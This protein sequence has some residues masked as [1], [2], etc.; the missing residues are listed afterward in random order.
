MLEQPT[1]PNHKQLKI[2]CRVEAGCLGPQGE[3]LINDYCDYAEQQFNQEKA[4]FVS[5]HVCPRTDRSLPELQYY[6]GNR[7][8][9][10]T[11]A[12]R[13]LN[14]F[15]HDIDTFEM[16]AHERIVCLIEQYMGR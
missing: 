7:R 15:E 9:S 11:Q 3:S 12:A 6:V 8:L 5:W 13:Y 4:H 10:Q 2:T 1:L 16:E 14:H